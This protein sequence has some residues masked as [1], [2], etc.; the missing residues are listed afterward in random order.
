M[1]NGT[2][3]QPVSDKNTTIM[4]VMHYVTTKDLFTVLHEVHLAIER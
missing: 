1:L 2:E 4:T 3:T